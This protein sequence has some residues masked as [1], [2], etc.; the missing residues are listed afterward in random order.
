M[1]PDAYF[2]LQD[3]HRQEMS[4]F[5]MAYAFNQQQLEEALV[6]IGATSV[7]ECVTV[8][9]HGDIVKKENADALIEMMKRQTRELRELVL[10]DEELA[11]AIFLY[12][13]D[14]HEYAINWSA[15]EDVLTALC[16]EWAD[17]EENN[18]LSAYNRAKRSHMKNA[19]EWGMV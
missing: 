11:E 10:S 19:V 16:I 9:N 8:F 3:R 12:E 14:N 2:Q 6:K 15:D 1:R 5:P 18:L 7:K 13:M 17:L 4:D